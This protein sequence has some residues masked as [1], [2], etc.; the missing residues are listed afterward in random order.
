M[1]DIAGSR[2]KLAFVWLLLVAALVVRAAVPQGYM[3][4]RADDGGVTVLICH[5]DAVLQIPV[6]KKE[7][8]ADDGKPAPEAC[9][10]A[11][12]WA[13]AAGGSPALDLPLPQPVAQS[14]SIDHGPFVL[15]AAARQRPPARGPPVRA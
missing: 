3:T 12:F 14:F 1:R 10:F 5:S 2:A 15:A 6:P 8:P 9:A 11:G 4:E 7:T 13:G